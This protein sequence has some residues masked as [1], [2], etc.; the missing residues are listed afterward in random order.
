MSALQILPEINLP[1]AAFATHGQSWLLKSAF[2]KKEGMA[3]GSLPDE[4]VGTV[5][6]QMLGDIPIERPS[7]TQL[8]PTLPGGPA[9]AR[10]WAAGPDTGPRSR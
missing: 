4:A 7:A 10:R 9:T 1:T 8:Q 5:V 3:F 2:A 6:A